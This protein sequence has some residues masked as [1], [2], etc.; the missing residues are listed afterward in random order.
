MNN[1]LVKDLKE[2]PYYG[3]LVEVGAGVP[4]AS[5]IYNEVGASKVIH[6]SLSPYS[7]ESQEEVFGKTNERSVSMEHIRYGLKNIINKHINN[8]K[9][10]FIYN[11]S[12]QVGRLDDD[13]STHGWIGVAKRVYPFESNKYN[14]WTM[15]I[16]HLSIH[17]K[18]KR[19]DT[20]DYIGD[21]GLKILHNFL[22]NDR[23]DYLSNSLP[24]DCNIDII[25]CFDLEN[26]LL[27]ELKVKLDSLIGSIG[28]DDY[29]TINPDGNIVRLED[30]FRNKDICLYKGSFSPP[31]LA[32]INFATKYTEYTNSEVV[33]MISVNT[34]EKGEQSI[35]NLIWRIEL[36]NK[37]GYTVIINKD[38]YFS[39]NAN[40]FRKKFKKPVSFLV[41]S[42]TV[43]RIL[44]DTVSR[45][46]VEEMGS[47]IEEDSLIMSEDYTLD[48]DENFKDV[49][50]YVAN[51]P[52]APLI[53]DCLKSKN[54]KILMDSS[55]ISS[56]M[57]RQHKADNNLDGLRSMMP[58]SIIHDYLNL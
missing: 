8:E 5:K 45:L 22:L 47:N 35:E 1:E 24:K 52:N 51:R 4:I 48:K 36:L 39:N 9:V 32:H 58:D 37:L 16:V 13:V 15:Q 26:D 42:D 44:T 23:K 28:K 38:G 40:F 7:K 50:F 10:N 43:N 2:S 18:M 49:T 6:S 30:I 27:T 19:T 29:I 33:F 25:S 31:T 14:Y 54:V 11:S 57:V 56:T 20:I 34:F 17:N 46:I 53:E 12:F 21:C 55:D 3:V 41:G